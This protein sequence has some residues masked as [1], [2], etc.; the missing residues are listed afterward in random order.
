MK[1]ADLILVKCHA[2]ASQDPLGNHTQD[3]SHGQALHPSAFFLPEGHSGKHQCDQSNAT[4]QQ[5]MRM[6]PEDAAHPF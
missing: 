4:S 1:D 2:E 6:L 5:P 3:C